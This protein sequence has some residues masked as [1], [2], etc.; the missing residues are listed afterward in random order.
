M[1]QLFV[2]GQEH[3]QL[4]H[5]VTEIDGKEQIT[6]QGYAHPAE[7]T[8]EL[9]K[10]LMGDI[11]VKK[12]ALLGWDDPQPLFYEE[13][14]EK[15]APRL[16]DAFKK[17]NSNQWIYFSIT[18]EKPGLFS[19]TLRVTDGIC[20]LDKEKLNF[21]FTNINV[22]ITGHSRIGI[23]GNID[24]FKT[25]DPR[26]QTPSRLYRFDFQPGKNY[27]KPLVVEGDQWL[28]EEQTQW[29][30]F[31]IKSDYAILP[32]KESSTSSKP[33]PKAGIEERLKKLKE[34]HTKGLIT[35]QE[36]EEKRKEILKEL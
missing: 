31:D 35:D 15:L 8:V 26:Q 11:S 10:K 1:I 23:K 22:E 36:Y 33:S 19:D 34:L 27:H 3:I 5:E 24:D 4:I 16:S 32:A 17:A 14:I 2:D 18:A 7:L 6:S 30:I 29:L 20:F 9:L 21:V 12:Y 28:S 25:G 13:E